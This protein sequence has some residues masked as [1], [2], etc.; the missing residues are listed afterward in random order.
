MA[1]KIMRRYPNVEQVGFVN[2]RKLEMMSGELSILGTLA[3]GYYL[4]SEFGKKCYSASGVNGFVRSSCQ[5]SEVTIALD[6]QYKKSRIEGLDFVDLGEIAYFVIPYSKRNFLSLF[7]NFRKR[8]GT[9]VGKN[10]W[11]VVFYKENRI[12]PVVYV[13][14]QT[15]SVLEKRLESACGSGSLAF[16]LVT[17]NNKVIQPS[18][19][20]IEIKKKSSKF[21]ISG[22]V[23]I[24]AKSVLI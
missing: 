7:E 10:A 19:K 22:K 24:L 4:C 2:E 16:Y 3:F 20:M 8:F 5:K 9:S 21:Q 14:D 12:W 6:V 11:G 23:E 1:K 15:G 17:G 18:G 13:E